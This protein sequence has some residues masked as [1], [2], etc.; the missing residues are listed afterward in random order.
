MAFVRLH[1]NASDSP[2]QASFAAASGTLLLWSNGV[3]T[4]LFHDNPQGEPSPIGALGDV[5]FATKQQRLQI[6]RPVL[7]LHEVVQGVVTLVPPYKPQWLLQIWATLSSLPLPA[8]RAPGAY[9][10]TSMICETAY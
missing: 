5:Q 10:F 8:L 6:V 9:L 1:K 4:C 3:V 2:H 7:L